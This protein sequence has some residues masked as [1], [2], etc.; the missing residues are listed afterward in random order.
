MR[1][2]VFLLFAVL[3]LAFVV[4][5]ATDEVSVYGDIAGYLTVDVS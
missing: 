4:A 2:S 1:A 5:Y 3:T